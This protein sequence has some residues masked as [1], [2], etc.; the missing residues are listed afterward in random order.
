M[1]IN[2]LG[3][4]ILSK[5]FTTIDASETVS[6]FPVQS[7]D[8]IRSLKFGFYQT[9]QAFSYTLEHLDENL[10]LGGMIIL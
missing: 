2:N 8:F 3:K 7:E 5:D 6:N 10:D 9:K 4:R 1:F